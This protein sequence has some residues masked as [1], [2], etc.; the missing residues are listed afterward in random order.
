MNRRELEMHLQDLL[1]GRLEASVLQELQH[2]LRSNPEARDTYRD[3]VHLQNA[4]QLRA[5]GID[6]LH[7]VPMNRVVD[8]R[9]RRHF[10]NAVVS[11]AAVLVVSALVAA[12][13]M[14][15]QPEPAHLTAVATA[16]SRWTVDGSPQD[17]AAGEWTVSAGSTVQVW[18]GM[19]RLRPESGA[20]MVVQG[21]AQVSFPEL[22]KPVV[23]DGWLWVDTAGSDMPFEIETPELLVRDIGTRFGVRV[24]AAAPAE[25]HLV[26]GK[27]EVFAKSTE[28]MITEL[29]PEGQA[30]AIPARDEPIGLALARDPF[31]GLAVLLAAPANY[32]TTVRGQNP[33]GYWRLEEAESGLLV[34]EIPDGLVGRHRQVVTGVP[35][36][37]ATGG[38]HGFSEGNRAILLRGMPGGAPLTLGTTPVHSGILFRDD[39]NGGG[40]LHGTIPDVTTDGAKWV[41]ASSP[42]YFG[43]DGRF[44]GRGERTA[45]DRGGSATLAFTPVDGVVYTLDA[46]LRG[47]TS[48]DYF[49]ALGFAD[50]QSRKGSK[51]AR[52]VDRAVSGRAWML[53]HGSNPNGVNKAWLGTS[54]SRGGT[55]DGVPFSSYGKGEMADVDLRIV[56][57]TSG[58]PGQWAA[59]WSVKRLGEDSYTPVRSTATL[60]N[61]SI[62]SVGLALG[63]GGI[64]GTIE[65]FSLRADRKLGLGHQPGPDVAPAQVARKEGAVSFWIRRETGEKRQEILCSAGEAPEDDSI[66]ARLDADGRIG[67]YMENGRYDVLVTSEES[68]VDG[69]WHHL[70]ASWS[71]SA[72]DLYLDG[73][74]VG[75][76]TEY[77][78]MQQGMLPELRFGGGPV[79]SKAAPFAGWIDEI[80]MWDRALT[81]GEVQHQFQSARRR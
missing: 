77:R 26:E 9:R 29:E 21:P 11:A 55:A 6:L 33:A 8:R 70:A 5:D 27:V 37:S 32:P 35:G 66:H 28:R 79:G 22:G 30:V 7:V 36:P 45:L 31:P 3:Y 44:L 72:V 62:T 13:I 75:S 40:P 52:F 15:R 60:L 12:L 18:S 23:K 61:E 51:D 2:E 1:E 64:S 80:A 69:R 67:F 48:D 65:S 25:V 63:G 16:G 53:V 10:W 81:P 73:R 42:S 56:L 41:A 43:A 54:G 39:F 34:N 4:L 68:I 46:A 57:D 49:V 38:F 14:T 71:P 58:G 78:G 76:D 24:P 19:V 59:T 47:V 20:S 74:L 50:G 17:P